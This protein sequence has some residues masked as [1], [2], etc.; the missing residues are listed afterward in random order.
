[1]RYAR[2]EVVPV[3]GMKLTLEKGQLKIKVKIEDK[4]HIYIIPA[5]HSY[6]YLSTKSS[7]MWYLSKRDGQTDGWTYQWN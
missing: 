3:N 6:H 5:K 4:N 7:T 2:Y 1:M